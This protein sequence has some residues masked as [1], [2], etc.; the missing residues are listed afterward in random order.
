[1]DYKNFA[2]LGAI[3]TIIF[4]LLLYFGHS[5]YVVFP[6]IG[7][8]FYIYEAFIVFLLTFALVYLHGKIDTIYELLIYGFVVPTV[9]LLLY[10]ILNIGV[11]LTTTQF[12]GEWFLQ[13]LIALAGGAVTFVLVDWLD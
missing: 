5:L 12:M 11:P 7:A 1:M 2:A 9:G 10:G 6:S 13:F 8:S 3:S 4:T